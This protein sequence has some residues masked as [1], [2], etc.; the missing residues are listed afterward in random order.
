M[1][2]ISDLEKIADFEI[3][4]IASQI[5]AIDKALNLLPHNVDLTRTVQK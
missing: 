1:S 2:L 3:E 4:K 5:E